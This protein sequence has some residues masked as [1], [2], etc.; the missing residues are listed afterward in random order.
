MKDVVIKLQSN[1]LKYDIQFESWLK[2]KVFNQQLRNSNPRAEEVSLSFEDKAV[3]WLAREI[4]NSIGKIHAELNWAVC[5]EDEP[6]LRTDGI[7]ELPDEWHIHLRFN[8]DWV[9]SPRALNSFAHMF[10]V[11]NLRYAWYRAIGNESFMLYRQEADDALENLYMEARSERVHVEP[12][13]L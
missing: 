12:F 13:R 3:D 1:E 6:A 9:G 8:D 11:A 2:N 10:V 4:D 7:T 5:K